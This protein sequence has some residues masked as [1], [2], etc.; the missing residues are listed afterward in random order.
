MQPNQMAYTK[1]LGTSSDSSLQPN[2][3]EWDIE[4]SFGNAVKGATIKA[5]KNQAMKT[6]EIF[7]KALLINEKLFINRVSSI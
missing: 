1:R 2:V 6:G 4:E 5:K 7:L 3:I